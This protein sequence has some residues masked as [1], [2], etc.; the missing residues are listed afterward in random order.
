MVV[1]LKCVVGGRGHRRTEEIEGQCVSSFVRSFVRVSR[2]NLII[3]L[4]CI[5]GV[6]RVIVET[7]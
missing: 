2:Y 4:L 1:L 3:Y 7:A 6:I 5:V